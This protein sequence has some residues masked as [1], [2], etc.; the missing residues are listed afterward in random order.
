[1]SDLDTRS[2]LQNEAG[3]VHLVT[4]KSSKPNQPLRG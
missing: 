1:M 3:M 4:I 2:V